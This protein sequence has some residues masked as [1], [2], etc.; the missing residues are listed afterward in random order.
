MP[1]TTTKLSDNEVKNAKPKEKDYVLSDGEGLQ[2]RVRANGS[3]LWN[4]NYIHPLSKKRL[5]IGFG[6]YPDIKLK[7][8]RKLHLEARELVAKGIDPKQQRSLKVD[9]SIAS[10][11]NT[12][13][14]VAVKWL[15]LKKSTVS[16]DHAI[17]IWRSLERH[18]FPSLENVPMSTL[19]PP[20][21]IDVLKPVEAKGSLET[22]K[23]LT[24]R[25]NEIMIFSINTGVIRTN[26]L[27][28]IKQ[29]FKKPKKTNMPALKPDELPYLM[30]TI[31]NASIKRTTRCLIEWQ[32]HTMT[33]PSEAAG[34]R[35]DEIDFDKGIWGIPAE[36]MKKQ[37]AHFIPLTSH[38]IS[39]LE[40]MMPISRHREFIFPADRDP[41]SHCNSQTANMALKRMGFKDRLVSHGLRSMASTI[42]NE[43]G[44]ESDLIESALSHVGDD[45]VRAA[46]NRTDFLE[47]RKVM[48]DWWSTHIAQASQGSLSIINQRRLS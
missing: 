19:T 46:Y 34:A 5:N 13:R 39:L 43:Q 36:R 37:K 22:V 38:S 8:V 6:K 35:W 41:K 25:L 33:R 24:Q 48:M 1:K 40:T 18:I 11:E 42:L 21:V 31:A 27:S 2:L 44:F 12:L 9:Q 47:R 16:S 10:T 29:S 26:P 45:K 20:Q 30:S 14:N 32:L 28:G 4:F 7:D 3:K 15:E 23:R 17:D